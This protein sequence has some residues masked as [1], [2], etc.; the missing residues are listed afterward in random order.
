VLAEAEATDVIAIADIDPA[1]GRSSGDAFNHQEDM[2]ARLFR[3]RS[4]AAFGI[5]TDPHPPVLDKVPETIA[6][7]DAVRIANG[8]LTVGEEEFR[9]ADALLRDGRAADA[10][11][12][13]EEL[14]KRYPA[15]WIDRVARERLARL[16]DAGTVSD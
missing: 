16:R 13:F 14:S 12:A 10:E 3:E 9:K 7:A 8:A 4:P 15:T 2:R 11:R 1:G 6:I 5:L